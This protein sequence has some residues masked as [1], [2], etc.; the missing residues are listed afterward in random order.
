[1]WKE[2]R[3][4]I[5]F[6]NVIPFSLRDLAK[7]W[8]PKLS[9]YPSWYSRLFMMQRSIESFLLLGF[10]LLEKYSLQHWKFKVPLNLYLYS[11]E[12]T[13]CRQTWSSVTCDNKIA[14][15]RESSARSV[16]PNRA[17][18]AAMDN[19]EYLWKCV[20][21]IHSVA[22]W[23]YFITCIPKSYRLSRAYFPNFLTRFHF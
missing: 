8:R 6:S 18:K 16:W 19:D 20:V 7:D 13:Y 2:Q 10:N 21:M 5:N 1:M 12:R 4:F 23:G 15:L 9:K 22:I 14:S 17:C 3:G 11:Q